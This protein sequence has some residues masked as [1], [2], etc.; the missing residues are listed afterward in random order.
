MPSD[1]SMYRRRCAWCDSEYHAS[2]GGCDCRYEEPPLC[3]CGDSSVEDPNYPGLC[4]NCIDERLGL[5]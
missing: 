1:W 2:E 5:L 4:E 3:E